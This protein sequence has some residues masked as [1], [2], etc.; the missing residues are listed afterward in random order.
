MPTGA[1][2][3]LERTRT[4]HQ[5]NL[6]MNREGLKGGGMATAERQ[7]WVAKPSMVS[8]AGGGGRDFRDLLAARDVGTG[9]VNIFGV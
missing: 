3:S 9:I 2:Q 4:T 7:G 1:S 5:L 6:V 8:P